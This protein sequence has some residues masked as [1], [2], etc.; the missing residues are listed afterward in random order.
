MAE[1]SDPFGLGEKR[2]MAKP[3]KMLFKPFKEK[4][5]GEGKSSAF[6]ARL[7]ADDARSLE[8]FE[9][10]ADISFAKRRI[11]SRAYLGDLPVQDYIFALRL[12]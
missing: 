4:E 10:L 9:R 2:R 8:E 11:G 5:L 1:G 12:S 7:S 3:E 6:L